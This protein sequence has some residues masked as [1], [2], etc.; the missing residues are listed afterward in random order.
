MGLAHRLAADAHY[1]IGA[2]VGSKFFGVLCGLLGFTSFLEA[3]DNP[4]LDRLVGIL[5]AFVYY[6]FFE[7]LFG[8]TVGKMVTGTK[9]VM[10]DGSVPSFTAILKRTLWRCVP[11][12]QFSF[13][14]S[15]QGWHD[16]KSDTMVVRM[17]R[18]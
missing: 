18:A 8:R 10:E 17:T 3:L 15:P 6:F 16:T 5:L 4:L 11:F 1:C 13:L 7:A 9:V 2:L 14:G 12:E